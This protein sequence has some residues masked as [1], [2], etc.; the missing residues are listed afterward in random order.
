MLTLALTFP[1]KTKICDFLRPVIYGAPFAQTWTTHNRV[2]P[3]IVS[4]PP[5]IGS[6]PWHFPLLWFFCKKDQSFVLGFEEKL[7]S[8]SPFGRTPNYP[9]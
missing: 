7:E 5:G 3:L 6:C 8:L 1:R 9:V 4:T 2:F